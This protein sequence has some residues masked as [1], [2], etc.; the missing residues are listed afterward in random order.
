M[1]QNG[2]QTALK[3]DMGT[4]RVW[5]ISLLA[6]FWSFFQLY[7]AYSPIDAIKA[8]NV[9]LAFA[10]VMV[11]FSFPKSKKSPFSVLKAIP[12]Y[13][14]TLAF[15][16]FCGALYV[17]WDYQGVFVERAGL[18]NNLDMLVGSIFIVI[19]LEAARRAIGPALPLLAII[20]IVYIFNGTFLPRYL[21]H[22]GALDL[23]S[24][25]RAVGHMFMSSDGVWGVPLWVSTSYVFLFV[26]FGSLLEK[27]GAAN[28]FVQVAFAAL[29]R[30]RGGPAKAAV[31]ASGMTGLVSGSSIANVATTGTFTIPLMKKVGLP[32]FKAGAIEVAA[33]T[34]GQLMPPVMGAAAFIMAEFLGL[35][36]LDIVRAA[37]L[38]ALLSYVALFYVVHLEAIKLNI[39]PLKTSE[40]PPFWKT[41][42]SGIHYLIPLF[43]LI[44]TLAVLRMSAVESAFRAVILTIV[45]I[46]VQGPIKSIFREVHKMKGESKVEKFSKLSQ[47]NISQNTINRISK[48]AIAGLAISLEETIQG[49][50][51]GAKNMMGI[52]VATAAAGIIVGTVTLTGLSGRFIELIEIISLGNVVLMLLLTALCSLVLGMGLPTTAN[53]IVMATLTAPVIVALGGKSGLVVPMLAA[54]LFVFYFGILAD[55]TPP[56]GLAAFAASAIAKSDPIQTGIQGFVYDLRTAILP[57]VFIFNLEIL[58]I[59]GLTEDGNIIWI[60]DIFKIGWICFSGLIA[61]FAFASALQGFFV[62]KCNI[63][64]RGFLILICLASFRPSIFTDLSGVPRMF[65]QFVAIFLFTVLYMIQKKRRVSQNAY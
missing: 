8:R 24:L 51:A 58:M 2:E 30:F 35:T 10:I 31:V 20:F 27:A 55:D 37:I 39:K 17:T 52:G 14:Y 49:L 53:Y 29:G 54:H 38:P 3:T 18:P 63:L 12:W 34:N 45:M 26:L 36:Y 40:I 57:F 22:D 6:L 11:F 65:V 46:I 19:L 44:Y 7:V 41:F 60:N 47:D 15:L 56:V 4:R 32:S 64:E 13:D 23:R 33:S 42:F 28:Y 5:F 25:E 9:H 43:M 21:A 48:S 16:G 61:M 1:S 62:D 59:G 50:I